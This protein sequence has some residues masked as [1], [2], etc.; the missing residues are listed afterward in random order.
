MFMGP[1][2]GGRAGRRRR[3][4]GGRACRKARDV[5]AC[6]GARDQGKPE[7]A[8]GAS[9]VGRGP[10][11]GP[12]AADSRGPQPGAPR[13]GAAATTVDLAPRRVSGFDV[14][15][16]ISP[17]QSFDSWASFVR[18]LEAEGVQRVWV[19]DSQLAMKDVYAG[20]VV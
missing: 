14:S 10:R 9:G 11:A 17:R 4:A 2:H 3:G 1:A 7:P 6:R 5:P 13:G 12:G 16:G 18:G 19:I 20:L 15:V 8:R